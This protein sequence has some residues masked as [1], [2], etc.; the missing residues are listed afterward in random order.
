MALRLIPITLREANEMIRRLHRHH[1]PVAGARF[2]IGVTNGE[3]LVGAVVVGRPVA[4]MTD[5]ATTAEVTRLVTDG[6]TNACSILYAAAARAAAAMGFERIQTF[7]LDD[8]PGTSLRAAGWTLEG[9]SGGGL[10]D[11]PGR[12][13]EDRHPTSAKQRWS[14][15]LR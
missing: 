14:K 11:R 13:R 4:R 5:Y 1:R 10:W 3:R 15:H 7:I 12:P 9:K 6:T 8:E 2:S